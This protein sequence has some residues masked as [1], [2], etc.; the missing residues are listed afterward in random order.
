MSIFLDNLE[1]SPPGDGSFFDQRILFLY[2][3]NPLTKN[4]CFLIA[5]CYNVKDN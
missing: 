2:F 3:V 5:E 1:P 4:A